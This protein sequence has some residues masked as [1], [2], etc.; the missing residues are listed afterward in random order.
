MTTPVSE[1]P[2]APDLN[3][4]HAW[5]ADAE[6]RAGEAAQR[7]RVHEEEV[8]ISGLARAAAVAEAGHRDK[9]AASLQ[10]RR[11]GIDRTRA[12][13]VS[14]INPTDNRSKGQ[15]VAREITTSLRPDT[16]VVTRGKDERP[17]VKR[18]KVTTRPIQPD[19]PYEIPIDR[20]NHD[21]N[22]RL[23]ELKKAEH[24][25]ARKNI[26]EDTITFSDM[27]IN[28]NH[29]MMKR[30]H[31][32]VGNW[33]VR[34]ERR[35]HSKAVDEALAAGE[36]TAEQ[37]RQAKNSHFP[38]RQPIV[39]RRPGEVDTAAPHIHATEMV[40]GYVASNRAARAIARNW[41]TD[42]G[43]ERHRQVAAA[44]GLGE[45]R[46]GSITRENQIRH[47]THRAA[48]AAVGFGPRSTAEQRLARVRS[49]AQE[50]R[51]DETRRG[52]NFREME[53]ITEYLAN[54]SRTPGGMNPVQRE[55]YRLAKERLDQLHVTDTILRSR[56]ERGGWYDRAAQRFQAQMDV[57]STQN[58]KSDHTVNVLNK[59]LH[60]EGKVKG[61]IGGN[62]IL[63]DDDF[64]DIAEEIRKANPELGTLFLQIGAQR[65]P[66]PVMTPEGYKYANAPLNRQE[67]REEVVKFLQMHIAGFMNDALYASGLRRG[68][69][70]D[71]TLRRRA[72]E[73]LSTNE[74]EVAPRIAEYA[75]GEEYR[76]LL[77]RAAEFAD[78]QRRHQEAAHRA[79]ND[80]IYYEQQ[81]WQLRQAIAAEQQRLRDEEAR[82]RRAANPA[83]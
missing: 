65:V 62:V 81:A 63:M 75:R 61:L 72:L 10:E 29:N 18:H 66:K 28:P 55:N 32:G 21:P 31:G 69:D 82:R 74:L 39:P 68:T 24:L 57:A 12:E 23:H 13:V 27:G 25:S 43:G 76:S 20:A 9:L 53:S 33:L 26:P 2:P 6:Y 22:H 51:N 46:L 77:G 36:I 14:V 8:S 42:P 15:V 80:A 67:R 54:L 48:E 11:F 34:A 56:L 47:V 35:A 44:L 7:A 16:G 19:K 3:Q 58:P 79:R 5:L 64:Q 49:D 45:D 37:A 38:S 70:V 30:G 52:D 41:A 50:R 1:Q 60:G 78:E 4:L 59:I 71:A 40:G 73:N 17:A 83:P